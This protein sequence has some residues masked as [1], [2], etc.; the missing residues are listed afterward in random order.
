M[1]KGGES[2]NALVAS[3]LL[4]LFATE[5]G[6][7]EESGKDMGQSGSGGGGTGGSSGTTGG[8]GGKGGAEGAVLHHLY[9]GC[10]DTTG[11]IQHY[12]ISNLT[13]ETTLVDTA[14]TDATN[15]NFAIN[16]EQ[17][18]VYIA[19]ADE[20]RITS[21]SRDTTTGKLTPID[22]V[23]VPG[24][25]EGEPGAEAPF[26]V[27]C[28]DAEHPNAPVNPATQT[29]TIDRTG[30]FLLASNWCANTVLV[31]EIK[32]DGTVG[33]LLQSLVDGK[34][35]HHTVFSP[36]DRFVLVPYFGSDFIAVYAFDPATGMLTRT[37][38]LTTE[39]P[40]EGGSSGPRHLALHPTHPS[41]LYS[42]NETAGSISFFLFD[43]S[44]GT[45]THQETVSS[46]PDDSPFTIEASNRSGSE[47]EID[48]SGK[49]LYVSNRVD[50]VENGSIGVYAIGTDGKLT[51]IEYEDTGGTT[52]RHFSLSPDGNLLVVTNQGSANM[53]IFSVDHPTGEL[54]AVATTPV[55]EK[56]FFARMVAP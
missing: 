1:T 23:S 39:V 24:N 25:A 37:D 53:R 30:N 4:A 17:T 22:Y 13:G 42:I 27:N 32:P 21:L 14:S 5:L 7:S 26:N 18:F 35:S 19:H 40:A 11:S 52:P 31:Y 48:S 43:N 10:R 9:V 20:G 3:F 8:G 45:L 41:W 15:S 56:P 34:S 6:C 2:S 38:P 46:L 50:G 47:I 36:M 33:S 54:T 16:A 51:S 44:D 55:C 28:L 49:F 29:L 12:Q